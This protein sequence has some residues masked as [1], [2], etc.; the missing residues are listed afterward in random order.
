MGRGKRKWEGWRENGKEN[1]ERKWEDG[2]IESECLSPLKKAL[3]MLQM[4]G[5]KTK[6]L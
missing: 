2:E 1:G 4:N 5:M 3:H 6:R